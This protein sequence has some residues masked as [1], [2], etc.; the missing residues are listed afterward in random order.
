MTLI[1]RLV[2]FFLG[3]ALGFII[4]WAFGVLTTGVPAGMSFD[5]ML[6]ITGI[7]IGFAGGWLIDESYLKNR[8]LQREL[9]AVR[10]SMTSPANQS[11]ESDSEPAHI[12]NRNPAG[13]AFTD[14]LRQRDA[15]M[16]ELR[17]QLTSTDI[18]VETLRRELESYQRTHPDNLTLIRGIG[19]VYQWKLRD[20]GINTYRQLA[21]ADP[22][23][24]RDL[25]SVKNWQ[26]VN[27]ESWIEQARDWVQRG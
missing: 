8:D 12:D 26:R 3:V 14:F 5:V 20:A 17:Q 15:E 21:G 27:I 22:H 7:I 2:L 6:L 11:P 13:E 1:P 24:I 16:R 10:S 19:P 18:T 9:H 4:A 23:M 25:L